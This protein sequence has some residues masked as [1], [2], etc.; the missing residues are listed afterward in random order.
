MLATNRL[1][2][3][4]RADLKKA[5]EWVSYGCQ[6]PST[7]LFAPQTCSSSAA[8]LEKETCCE[9][10]AWKLFFRA[11]G[12]VDGLQGDICAGLTWRPKT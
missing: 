11:I 5:L 10:F 6:V 8:L 4:A 9:L 12:I 2:G 1:W 7:N 3:Q